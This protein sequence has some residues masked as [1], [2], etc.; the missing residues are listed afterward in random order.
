MSNQTTSNK[1]YET[2]KAILKPKADKAFI[3]NK[4]RELLKLDYD[5]PQGIKELLESTQHKNSSPLVSS[6]KKFQEEVKSYFNEMDELMQDNMFDELQNEME[7]EM[8]MSMNND[9]LLSYISNNQLKNN[10]ALV[11][12]FLDEQEVKQAPQAQEK[13]KKNK[14]AKKSNAKKVSI[15]EEK[16]ESKEHN[17]KEE[18]NTNS[19]ENQTNFVSKDKEVEKQKG[20]T[21]TGRT[22]SNLNKKGIEEHK[23]NNSPSNIEETNNQFEKNDNMSEKEKDNNEKKKKCSNLHNKSNKRYLKEYKDKKR[24]YFNE[25]NSPKISEKIEMIEDKAVKDCIII[26]N[27]PYMMNNKEQSSV[28][29]ERESD[30]KEGNSSFDPNQNK[31]IIPSIDY[32]KYSDIFRLKHLLQLAEAIPENSI[33]KEQLIKEITDFINDKC[34][35]KY[36]A[37]VNH[38]N[39]NITLKVIIDAIVFRIHNKF[40]RIVNCDF[41]RT[42]DDIREYINKFPHSLIDNI[43]KKNIPIMNFM[44]KIMEWTRNAYPVSMK[45]ITDYID[46]NVIIITLLDGIN[47]NDVNN[48][49]IC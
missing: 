2:L 38:L 15:K 16:K 5:Y 41:P 14:R 48:F 49:W 35:N 22:K 39:L 10:H 12:F 28:K 6:V 25:S 36:V 29:T 40:Q 47:T 18:S 19:T 43:K 42:I 46:D 13:G 27:V 33:Q 7:K 8:I 17:N 32:K 3:I 23:G 21:E 4:S 1:V 37:G 24:D 44:R 11:N 30:S 45:G 20:E 31:T 26:P 9:N 34:G